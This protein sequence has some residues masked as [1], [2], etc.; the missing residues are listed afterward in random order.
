[1]V[2]SYSIMLNSCHASWLTQTPTHQF[3]FISEFVDLNAFV[4]QH[5]P[6]A[7]IKMSP[8]V[9]HTLWCNENVHVSSYLDE[10]N[11]DVKREYDHLGPF[12]KEWSYPIQEVPKL[13]LVHNLLVRC[14]LVLS[15]YAYVNGR[16]DPEIADILHKVCHVYSRYAIY[17]MSP[18]IFGS[19]DYRKITLSLLQNDPL[20]Y[21][22]YIDTLASTGCI[23]S[24]GSIPNLEKLLAILLK[25][26]HA[27]DGLLRVLRDKRCKMGQRS[28][29]KILEEEDGAM[30]LTE[31]IKLKPETLQGMSPKAAFELGFECGEKQEIEFQ[32]KMKER[33]E[34]IK[35][36]L[37]G[38]GPIASRIT[39]QLER[40]IRRF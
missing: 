19:R 8:T 15:E 37:A 36:S 34:K 16:H 17:A 35:D 28:L 20:G 29:E 18:S 1:M 6:L 40:W 4:P 7:V 14:D 39:A 33:L 11:Y 10:F 32:I 21:L 26:R 25:H 24:A 23:R 13:V 27:D 22:D 9:A 30:L 2:K 38:M 5:G 3:S 31:V 12:L